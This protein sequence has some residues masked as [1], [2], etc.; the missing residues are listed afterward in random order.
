[1]TMAPVSRTVNAEKSAFSFIVEAELRDGNIIVVNSQ[2][3]GPNSLEKHVVAEFKQN[4][5]FALSAETEFNEDD[6]GPG[7]SGYFYVS[8]TGWYISGQNY[9]YE[10]KHYS[11]F[12]LNWPHTYSD[13]VFRCYSDE[14]N[15]PFDY[16]GTKYYYQ[17]CDQHVSTRM[18]L[19]VYYIIIPVGHVTV[20]CS[21]YPPD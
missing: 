6:D 11:Y 2:Y 4:S 8:V 15:D 12:Y 16:T 20:Q 3:T 1:M 13:L 18:D 5:Q 19:E 10:E 21:V 17:N 14:Y 9:F 7:A